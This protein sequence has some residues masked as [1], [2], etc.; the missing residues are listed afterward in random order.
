VRH[1]GP[2]T[3]AVREGVI[4]YLDEI[5]RKDTVVII[6]PLTDYRRRLPIEK[7]RH[8]SRDAAGIY[9]CRLLRQSGLSVSFEGFGNS[10]PDSV[11]WRWN[12]IT[13][14]RMEIVARE[15]EIESRRDL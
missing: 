15:G 12:L 6:H 3:K 14:S 7:T 4:C 11:S 1:D 2:L 5:A 9:A 13:D 10:Q 8:C